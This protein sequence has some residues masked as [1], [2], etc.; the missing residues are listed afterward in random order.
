MRCIHS[1]APWLT[2]CFGKK[3]FVD[4]KEIKVYIKSRKKLN[5]DSFQ[6]AGTYCIAP[7]G[8]FVHR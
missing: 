6:E 4:W 2:S 8:Q 1:L 3:S 7:V 5:N